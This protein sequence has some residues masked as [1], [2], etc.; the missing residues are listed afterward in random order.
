MPTPPRTTLGALGVLLALSSCHRENKPTPR[1][2]D[3][4]STPP[5]LPAAVPSSSAPPTAPPEVTPLSPALIADTVALAE[6]MIDPARKG[7][8][9]GAMRLY[10]H[11]F[12]GYAL[13]NVALEGQPHA[14]RTIPL[15]DGL[16]ERVS[17][18]EF[19]SPFGP[20]HLNLAGHRIARSAAPLGHLA[21][22]LAARQKLA[23]LSSVQS[24]LLEALLTEIENDIE[25]APT[26]LL[27]TYGQRIWP[28][29]NEVIVA[30][31]VLLE[32]GS[33]RRASQGLQAMRAALAALESE[34]LPP[35]RL[36]SVG[37]R[38]ADVPRGCALSWTI[39]MRGL[40]D[41]A[42]ASDLYDK[43]RALYWV[44]LGPLAG[45][46]EWPPGIERPAD[47]DSGPIVMGVGTAA[48]AF[49]MGAARLAGQF[50]DA[51]ALLAAARMGGL[52]ERTAKKT[53]SS[54]LERAISLFSRTARTWV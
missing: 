16:I 51:E 8:T 23:P 41:P 10:S 6:E 1:E 38:G 33:S 11:A 5:S 24:A 2:H 27:P 50:D 53:P 19:S 54:W 13:V 35:S 30:A 21:L 34:G 37:K 15:L 14:S 4:G 32:K 18:A 20:A 48:T 40:H 45:F 29:D 28:A 12:A 42:S 39:A 7:S 46:R 22:L 3:A 47:V 44:E 9:A 36:P 17:S 26:H 52:D 25:R 43:Y 49:G 31:L